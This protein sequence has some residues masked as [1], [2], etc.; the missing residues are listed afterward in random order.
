VAVDTV[1]AIGV[2]ALAVAILYIPPAWRA[3]FRPP[4]DAVEYAVTAQRLASFDSYALPMLGRHYPP[5]Y[6]FGFPALLAPAYW[7]PGATLAN[8]IYAVVA[9]GVLGV[10][11]TYA[12][13]RLLWGRSVGLVA[14]VALL[15]LPQYPGWSHAIMSETATVA[16]VAASALLLCLAEDAG[17][18]RR[19]LVLLAG[20]GG[21]AG[22]AILVRLANVVLPLALVVALV[23]VRRPRQELA[24]GV[25]AFGAGPAV[26]LVGLAVYGLAT[27][28][29]VLGTGY[30][31][32]VPKWYAAPGQAFA[33]VYAFA[34]P[35]PLGDPAAPAGLPNALYYAR[36][37]LGLLP[38]RSS[39]FLTVELC[40]L[41][42]VGAVSI[43][44]DRRQPV[45]ACAVFAGLFSTLTLGLYAVYFVRDVR[46]LA[47]L[48]PLAAL[49]I[50]AG[51]L[52]GGR[53]LASGLRQRRPARILAR[54]GLGAVIVSI[55]LV[56][57]ARALGPTLEQCYAYQ[58]YL[59]GDSALY[60]FPWDARTIDVY[61]ATTPDGS[62]LVTDLALPLLGA[63]GLGER[64]TIVP[65]TQGE[66]WDKAPLRGAPQVADRQRI[67]VDA[68]R[69][70]VPV[71]TDSFTIDPI[72][73]RGP[74]DFER[75]LA[76]HQAQLLPL[77]TDGAITIYQLVPSP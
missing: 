4:P 3:D 61:R 23:A 45:R 36:S 12:V 18:G 30:R 24:R 52:A 50:G 48:A 14:A 77:T 27:F 29:S 73:T 56:G 75:F 25:L 71:Y 31:Y 63:A 72:R 16:L 41:A 10:V 42:C 26:A 40:A 38:E 47:P 7:L 74:Q 57:V 22:L 64:H 44:R 34:A 11:L 59:R 53:L 5:R 28:G 66:Y 46:F 19:R 37:V 55:A 67:I 33:L 51:A 43:A 1:L 17:G 76:I 21:V 58:R 68:L 65:L 20:L 62:L 8:G 69:R 60:Q 54:V 70:G 9:Y 2:V 13:G 32:W 6:P 49:C 15:L 35:A 39:L